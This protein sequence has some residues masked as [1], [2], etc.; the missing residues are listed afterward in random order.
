MKVIKKYTAIM[1]ASLKS[2]LMYKK[3]LFSSSFF[4]LCIMYVFIFLWKAAYGEKEN[5]KGM[6]Y[7]QVI[8]YL[9]IT[10]TV[11]LSKINI[12]GKISEEVKSG[13]LSYLMN[14][15]Y[16]FILYHFF[17]ELG[18]TIP[19][20]I[21]NFITG[22]IIILLVGTCNSPLYNL[23]AVLLA[24]VMSIY[25]DFCFSAFIGI[26]A[27]RMEDITG[28]NMI[29]SK[30]NQILGGLFIPI[31][32]MPLWMQKMCSFLPFSTIYNL[33]G[34]LFVNFDLLNVLRTF[35][36]QLFW[37]IISSLILIVFYRSNIKYLSIN[38]G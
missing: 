30:L 14:K 9:L 15:P 12:S 27:F 6:A 7:E 16:N 31:S 36:F 32:F 10:E 1:K 29:Y 34:T 35:G 38:G 28:A 3:A 19:K 8:Y 22:Y 2:N 26:L 24:I 20:I 4:M 37:A 13:L 18:S 33:P 5:I 21:I 23:P 25:I 17:T 11:A